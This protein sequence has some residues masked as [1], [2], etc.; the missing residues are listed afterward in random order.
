[1]P[2]DIIDTEYIESM[3]I[4]G[5][6]R[7]DEYV[8]ESFVQI[9]RTMTTGEIYS[10]EVDPGV[11][12]A[13]VTIT[14]REN[15]VTNTFKPS[16]DTL[17]LTYYYDSLFTPEPGAVY[18]LE[19]NAGDLPT[20]TASTSVPQLPQIVP[21]SLALGEDQLSLTL[22]LTPDTHQYTVYLFSATSDPDNSP[23]LLVEGARQ[24][25]E[26]LTLSWNETF[27]DPLFIVIT[28][29]DEHLVR[30]GNSSISFIPNTFHEDGSTVEGGFG[31]FGSVSVSYIELN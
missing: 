8:G 4:F 21:G 29:L 3:N 24:G 30:Y 26:A 5:V 14:N 17:R 11:Y 19:I 2:R 13:D 6:I 1:M 28:A 22:L 7:V 18:D 27:G 12:D 23:Q 15:A 16:T 10:F 25:T 20:L 31:C 9:Q